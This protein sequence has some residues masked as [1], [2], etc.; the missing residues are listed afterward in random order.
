MLAL[1]AVVLSYNTPATTEPIYHCC[2][3]VSSQSGV[4]DQPFGDSETLQGAFNRLE[5]IRSLPQHA[6]CLLVAI[7]GGVGFAPRL[8]PP[9]GGAPHQP[10]A[11]SLA[12]ARQQVQGLPGEVPQL[13]CFAWV[14]LRAAGGGAASHAR[15]AS[16]P[17]PA[18][19][20]ELVLR[21]GL[22]L[23]DADDRVFGRCAPAPLQPMA[24]TRAPSGCALPAPAACATRPGARSCS[25]LRPCPEPVLAGS[26]RG[27]A[28]AP[29]AS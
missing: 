14:V 17:L 8:P 2:A 12:A 23:G 10:A 22:E 25:R 11:T 13:E 15:T 29:S 18:A 19:I 20:A 27:R 21:D 24:G 28:A 1:L 16:F 6:G 26:S 7:E 9:C 5:S 4:P 3:G